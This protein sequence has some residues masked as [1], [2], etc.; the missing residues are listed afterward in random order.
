[1]W[2]WRRMEKISWIERI[3]NEEVLRTVEEKR[4]LIDVI[5]ERRWKMVGHAMRHPEE[6]HNIIL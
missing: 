2:C 1:M 4:T 6:L 5:R 3:T